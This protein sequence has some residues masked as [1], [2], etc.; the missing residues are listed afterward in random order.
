MKRRRAV[1]RERI[2]AVIRE[3]PEFDTK[4]IANEAKCSTKYV[5]T[6]RAQIAQ[7]GPDDLVPQFVRLL[8]LLGLERAQALLALYQIMIEE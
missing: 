5:C 8:K 4:Q 2:V 6:T 7:A 3:H 1:V